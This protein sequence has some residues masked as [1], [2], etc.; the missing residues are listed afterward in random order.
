MKQRAFF[1]LF[2]GVLMKQIT[3]L[4]LEDEGPALNECKC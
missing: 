2:K 3:Q 4:F 1:I